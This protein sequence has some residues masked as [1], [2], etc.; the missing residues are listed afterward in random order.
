MFFFSA[1]PTPCV[2]THL[3]SMRNIRKFRL[4]PFRR[5]FARARRMC[6]C[7]YY[8]TIAET[9]GFELIRDE[10]KVLSLLTNNGC[11]RGGAEG[12]QVFHSKFNCVFFAIL[13]YLYGLKKKKKY[14]KQVRRQD[15]FASLLRVLCYTRR[16]QSRYKL[17][18]I[19]RFD[20]SFQFFFSFTQFAFHPNESLSEI[21]RDRAG[22]LGAF[23][24][25]LRCLTSR[26]K[27]A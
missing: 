12:R 6:A 16:R 3:Y 13:R 19:S 15:K 2:R 20:V 8:C 23:L 11:D 5:K 9:R 25:R 22:I 27:F 21:I 24:L 18:A 7:V 4:R 14:E 26:S 17:F 1:K 10:Q